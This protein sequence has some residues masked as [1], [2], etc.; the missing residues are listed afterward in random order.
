VAE[1]VRHHSPEL[2]DMR[3]YTAASSFHQKRL[4]WSVLNRKVFRRLDFDLS[5][6]IILDLCRG[7][8]GAIEFVLFKLRSR[9]DGKCGA[10]RFSLGSTL[11]NVSSKSTSSSISRVDY[12]E[13]KQQCLQQQEDIAVLSARIRRMQHVLDLKEIRFDAWTARVAHEPVPVLPSLVV[14]AHRP[15]C[16]RSRAFLSPSATGQREHVA[17]STT[18]ANNLIRVPNDR[19]R[20]RRTRTN[21]PS[22]TWR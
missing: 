7:S 11:A 3:N 16:R 14:S 9:H 15:A 8:P 18:T 5:E 10:R 4:N 21:D 6:S 2:I 1:L 19:R 20:A 13:L 17:R 12:E 22:R